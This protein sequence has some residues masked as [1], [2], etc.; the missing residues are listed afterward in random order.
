MTFLHISLMW[1]LA[2][3]EYFNGFLLTDDRIG[4]PYS[5]MKSWWFFCLT[6]T[7]SIPNASDEPYVTII[8]FKRARFIKNPER[9]SK[10]LFG[11]DIRRNIYLKNGL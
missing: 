7:F 2:S 3:R 9:E 11:L 8:A 4:K 5:S 1:A 6:V 10:W